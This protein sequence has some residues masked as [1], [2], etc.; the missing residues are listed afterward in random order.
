[1][2]LRRAAPSVGDGSSI[3]IRTMYAFIGGF[4]GFLILLALAAYFCYRRH[5]QRRRRQRVMNSALGHTLISEGPRSTASD[6]VQMA[7]YFNPSSQPRPATRGPSPPQQQPH[8]RPPPEILISSPPP[9]E[10]PRASSNRV[11]FAHNTNKTDSLDRLHI[12]ER[13]AALSLS[14]ARPAGPTSSKAVPASPSTSTY[15][16]PS[17][18]HPNLRRPWPEGLLARSYSTVTENS[19]GDFSHAGSPVNA[20][21]KAMRAKK[22][23]ELRSKGITRTRSHLLLASDAST[24]MS[25]SDDGFGYGFGVASRNNSRCGGGGV[26]MA[27]DGDARFETACARRRGGEEVMPMPMPLPLRIPKMEMGMGI[28]MEK[29]QVRPVGMGM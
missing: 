15:L 17:A 10:A 9:N 20:A 13:L 3:S 18:S 19:D 4:V 24:E 23:A 25:V 16:H 29:G 26:W 8:A 11:K 7:M 2:I 27:G 12:Q 28:G 14:T 22:D 1:M 5:I 21:F 6:P